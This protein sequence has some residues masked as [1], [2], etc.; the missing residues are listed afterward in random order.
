VKQKLQKAASATF[1]VAIM[2]FGIWLWYTILKAAGI[3]ERP[4]WTHWGF[5]RYLYATH[6]FDDLLLFA[7]SGI[8]VYSIAI[9]MDREYGDAASPRRNWGWAL[10]FAIVVGLFAFLR[11]AGGETSNSDLFYP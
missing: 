8:A 10:L 11:F 6:Q 1:S 4:F 2:G 9:N 3:G 7:I 5:Y